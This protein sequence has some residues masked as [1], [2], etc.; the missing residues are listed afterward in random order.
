MKFVA[1][2]VLVIGSTLMF[3]TLVSHAEKWDKNDYADATVK[4]GYYKVDSIK[5]SS[6]VV[7]WTEKYILTDEGATLID[8]ELSKYEVCRENIA[9]KGKV[10]QFQLDYQLEKSTLKYRGV[11]TRYYN[12][13]NK[14]ICT[15]KNTGKEFKSDWSKIQRGSPM[16][17]AHYDLVTKYKIKIQ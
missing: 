6:T 8:T 5:S 1:A 2:L 12:K 17:K 11:A 14:L 16:Q 4:A 9:K 3:D 13:D 7:S 10:T 15:G